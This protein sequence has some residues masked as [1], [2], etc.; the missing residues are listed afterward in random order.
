MSIGGYGGIE[1]GETDL[2]LSRLMQLAEVLEVSLAE[3]VEP[4]RNIIHSSGNTVHV[5][6]A[7]LRQQS[8]DWHIYQYRSA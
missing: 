8:H 1:R 4:N 6:G 2:N 3:L 7:Y 5:T